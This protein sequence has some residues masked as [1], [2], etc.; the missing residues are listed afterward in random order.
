[1]PTA[2]AI[3][4]AVL[5]VLKGADFPEGASTQEVADHLGVPYIAANRALNFLLKEGVLRKRQG[6][7]SGPSKKPPQIFF[8]PPS[9]VPPEDIPGE[10]L[11]DEGD[12]PEES[13]PTVRAE[14]DPTEIEDD[15]VD[16]EDAAGPGVSFGPPQIPGTPAPAT[17]A[18]LKGPAAT[19]MGH[20]D[21]REIVAGQK[22]MEAATGH[23][24]GGLR[25]VERIHPIPNGFPEEELGTLGSAFEES[26]AGDLTEYIGGLY[27]GGTYK[28]HSCNIS[29]NPSGGLFQ[30]VTVQGIPKPRTE[31][32]R[33]WLADYQSKNAARAGQAAGGAQVPD[34]MQLMEMSDK[35]AR[36]ARAESDKMFQQTLQLL[37]PGK[38]QNSEAQVA[39]AAEHAKELNRIRED[40]EKRITDLKENY[41]TQ[42]KKYET[43]IAALREDLRN[44][45]TELTNGWTKEKTEIT[46]AHVA[47][48]QEVGA[49]AAK[50]LAAAKEA[51]S[52]EI[53]AVKDQAVKDIAAAS[54]KNKM[55]AQLDALKTSME[56]KPKDINYEVQK[57]MIPEMIRM[58]TA[59][60][61]KA[62]GIADEEDEQT[63]VD[64][65]KNIVTEV[66]PDVV[67]KLATAF[68]GIT[69]D[70]AP[71]APAA[72]PGLLPPP[73]PG[74][75]ARP[76][77]LPTRPPLPARPQGAGSA[78]PLMR[79]RGAP[80]PPPPVMVAHPELEVQPPAGPQS[81]G[82]PFVELTEEEQ[83]ALLVQNQG[84][85]PMVTAPGGFGTP[86]QPEILP[87]GQEIPADGIPGGVPPPAGILEPTEEM[88]PVQQATALR[89]RTFFEMIFTEMRIDS[90][91]AAA[92]QSPVGG[93][94][95]NLEDLYFKL[96][97]RVRKA[98]EFAPPEKDWE[99]LLGSLN[100]QVEG[101]DLLVAMQE[102]VVAHPEARPWLK[103]FLETGP[104]VPEEEEEDDGA[105]GEGE[106]TS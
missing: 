36:E 41:N 79:E 33:L 54:E 65:A 60:A 80:T 68:V 71:A 89:L 45:K 72:R 78:N 75:P 2:P 58:A 19:A 23:K 61:K 44:Q 69:G 84:L 24:P 4:P 51:A 50:E 17:P 10:S 25:K 67:K 85:P 106:E 34:F 3:S 93:T 38:Q 28:I 7:A 77:A 30:V 5:R 95:L 53:Q 100:I 29:G 49:Q 43:D 70:K 73:R 35:K 64:V 90:D 39:T 9:D 88:D 99:G 59:Q 102:H 94:D 101:D 57:G 6:Q 63:W 27:G 48:L 16:L 11:P 47:K 56:Q 13:M 74:Q 37:M 97:G 32:G 20:F 98:F 55:Q 105:P 91:A 76:G 96:P 83:A 40:T 22:A 26:T 46:L 52:K 82:P 87:P 14:A 15:D 62:A 92:W 18:Q 8:V 103:D 86:E 42:I 31:A 81:V 66:G 104:W 12:V 1:M 21:R